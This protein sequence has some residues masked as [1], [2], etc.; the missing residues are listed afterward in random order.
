MPSAHTLRDPHGRYQKSFASSVNGSG[1]SELARL[2][3]AFPACP[4]PP[5]NQ[6]G[7]YELTAVSADVV[8]F[9]ALGVGLRGSH[10]TSR[11]GH[12]VITGIGAGS[13]TA[14]ERSFSRA[15]TDRLVIELTC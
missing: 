14:R 15:N 1:H 13:H 8:A 10:E 11:V 9:G 7:F 12:R 6:P 5:Q 3:E 2:A 4:W